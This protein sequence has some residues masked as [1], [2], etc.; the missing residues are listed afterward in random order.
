MPHCNFVKKDGSI[1]QSWAMKDDPQGR[2]LFHTELEAVKGP[3]RSKPPLS[4]DEM[5]AELEREL[6]RVKK[7]VKDP[8]KRASEIRNIFALILKIKYEKPPD[9]EEAGPLA[10]RIA[11][12]K[13]KTTPPPSQT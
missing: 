1:C 13:K 10:D 11:K 8:L 3:G 7:H 12:W 5:I 2:C 4:Q 6:R 9:P